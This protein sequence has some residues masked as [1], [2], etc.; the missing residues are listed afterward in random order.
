MRLSRN[1]FAPLLLI[2]MPPFALVTP[3][4]LIVPPVQ[5]KRPLAVTLATVP[6]SVP[7]ERLMA[8]TVMLLE[9]KLTAPLLILSGPVPRLLMAL[10]KL[11]VAPEKLL[12]P[13]TL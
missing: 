13:V 7:P 10:L 6:P 12:V 8:A 9:L 5:L 2:V 1:K 4:P 11:T 3:L